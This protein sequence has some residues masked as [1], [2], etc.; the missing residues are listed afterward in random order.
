M[1]LA[2]VFFLF[3]FCWILLVIICLYSYTIFWMFYWCFILFSIGFDE[4]VSWQE[5]MLD[6][7]YAK[8]GSKSGLVDGN[9]CQIRSSYLF[10][11]TLQVG[12][13]QMAYLL[14]YKT[15]AAAGLRRDV[16][17]TRAVP[18]IIGSWLYVSLLGRCQESFLARVRKVLRYDWV[19]EYWVVN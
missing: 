19:S 13:T 17:G 9:T 1:P 15:M 10:S 11:A 6:L 14:S 5:Q 16:L 7:F 8:F 2:L 18:I 12:Q 3:S 4:L